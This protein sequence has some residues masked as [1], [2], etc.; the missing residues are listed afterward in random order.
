[1]IKIN[2]NKLVKNIDSM[3]I[4]KALILKV[5]KALIKKAIKARIL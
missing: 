5:I 4:I 1:M 2:I 3:R